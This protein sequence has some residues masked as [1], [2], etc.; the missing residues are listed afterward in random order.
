MVGELDKY[1]QI[2]AIPSIGLIIATALIVSIGNAGCFKNSR[3]LSAW[4]GLVPRQ[5]SS[6]GK[7][8]LLGISRRADIYLQT[9]LIQGARSVL[10]TKLR[11]TVTSIN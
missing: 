9:L 3:Q 8:K 4:L 2:I 11:F 10:N 5:A 7:K 6:G 1:Q